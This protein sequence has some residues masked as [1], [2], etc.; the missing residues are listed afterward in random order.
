M[1]VW[2]P[3]RQPQQHRSL[4]LANISTLASYEGASRIGGLDELATCCAA[5]RI[6]RQVRRA[7]LTRCNPDIK[8]QCQGMIADIG[9]VMTGRA[10]ALYHRLPQHIVEALHILNCELPRIEQR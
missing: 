4:E 3:C 9:R 1:K 5:Q 2:C 10:G 7:P 8:R 6:Q